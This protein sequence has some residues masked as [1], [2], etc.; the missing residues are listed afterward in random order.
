M[1]GV[2][3]GIEYLVMLGGIIKYLGCEAHG[4]PGGGPQVADRCREPR[5]RMQWLPKSIQGQRLAAESSAEINIR[6]SYNNKKY[7]YIYTF[8]VTRMRKE[9]TKRK[10]KLL[11]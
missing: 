11:P 8:N 9:K 7:I 3:G 1:Q 10:E 2:G 5:E 4:A 6:I